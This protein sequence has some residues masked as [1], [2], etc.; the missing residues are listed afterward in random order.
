MADFL[1]LEDFVAAGVDIQAGTVLD[2]RINPLSDW[3]ASG[4]SA[5]A[6]VPAMEPTV[7]AYRQQ[8]GAN[9]RF[10]GDLTALLIAAGFIGGP[11]SGPAG[12]QLGGTYPDPD[13]RG[14][15]ETGG[16]TLLAF[17]AVAD[18]QGLVRNGATMEG[19][20]LLAGPLSSTDEAIARWDGAGGDTLQDSLV[21]INDTGDVSPSADDAQD[22]GAAASRFAEARCR[23]LVATGGAGAPTLASATFGGIVGAG[24]LDGAASFTFGGG[25][26]APTLMAVNAVQGA[27]ATTTVS[28][29]AGGGAM[30]GSAFSGGAGSVAAMTSGA[31][32]YGSFTGGYAFGYTGGSA[33]V[34]NTGAGAFLWGYAAPSGAG[35]HVLQATGEGAFARGRTVGTGAATIS[36]A[37]PGS[38][39]GGFIPSAGTIRTTAGAEGGF[40]SGRAAGGGIV[41]A[42]APGSFA[43]GNAEPNDVRASND[44][45]FAVG[46]AATADIVASA[47]NSSQ[48][49]P[50]TNAEADTLS[51][52]TGMRLKGTD[53]APGTPRTGDLWPD[54]PN[55]RMRS[56]SVDVNFS[57][58]SVTGSRG[59]NAALASLLTQL[60]AMNLIQDN[61][62]A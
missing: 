32:A 61:T 17:G 30:V 9:A 49:G 2:D 50:G 51:V 8:R 25:S 26:Y 24:N 45:S 46:D 31:T 33:T 22:L 43:A 42:T 62:T 36:A 4:L 10:D 47:Q 19:T 38:F 41:E 53:G 5:I 52:G 39:C 27:G 37:G 11:P 3:Q 48:F 1:V 57:N 23:V 20:D 6:F 18:G 34:Q 44:G 15:R 28:H 14:M 54:G 55:V 21:L 7:E 29:A 40:A 13:V 56:A 59:G 35:V 12:G 58:P 16:P 60:A